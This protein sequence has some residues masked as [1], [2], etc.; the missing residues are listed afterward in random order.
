M[1]TRLT[2]R[3]ENAQIPLYLPDAN[4]KQANLRPSKPSIAVLKVKSSREIPSVDIETIERGG[5]ES[6]RK[7]IRWTRSRKSQTEDNP[8]LQ[9]RRIR[10]AHIPPHIAF[11]DP[12]RETPLADAHQTAF[13]RSSALAPFNNPPNAPV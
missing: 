8:T 9:I 2:E 1:K 3:Y 6:Q 13:R 5:K 10:P 11:P 4:E 7:S 12:R